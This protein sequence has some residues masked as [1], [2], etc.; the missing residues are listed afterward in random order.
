MQHMFQMSY[1]HNFYYFFLVGSPKKVQDGGARDVSAGREAGDESQTREAVDVQEE[2]EEYDEDDDEYE[3]DDDVV[4][5][6]K[7][8]TLQYIENGEAKVI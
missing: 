8:I 5:F 7:R 4:I 3:D 1:F 6:Q 2:Q